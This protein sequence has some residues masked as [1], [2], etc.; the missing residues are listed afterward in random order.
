[1]TLLDNII[2]AQSQLVRPF[3]NKP[4][5]IR[6][7]I[8]LVAEFNPNSYFLWM[9]DSTNYGDS[10]NYVYIRLFPQ[11]ESADKPIAGKGYKPTFARSAIA[12]T[13]TRLGF[14]CGVSQQQFFI[15]QIIKKLSVICDTSEPH[16]PIKVI[17][18]CRPDFDD[19]VSYTD[20]MA[21]VRYGRIDIEQPPAIVR[22]LNMDY[23]KNPWIFSFEDYR[24]K[25]G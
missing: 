24:L 18:F 12:P 13:T 5:L 6:T 23:T 20:G 8:S 2:A 10:S 25:L 15:F 22:G 9:F 17:D 7:P 4:L 11:Y 21:T 1:M 19:F 16:A 3:V 14:R